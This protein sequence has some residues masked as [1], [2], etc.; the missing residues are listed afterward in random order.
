[1]S[2]AKSDQPASGKPPSQNQLGRNAISPLPGIAFIG[3]DMV[4]S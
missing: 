1:M 3:D 4:V 2:E